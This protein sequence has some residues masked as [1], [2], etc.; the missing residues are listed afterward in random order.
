MNK[1]AKKKR[2][3]E[4]NAVQVEVLVF[5]R[6]S[7]DLHRKRFHQNVQPLEQNDPEKNKTPRVFDGMFHGFHV[8]NHRNST[9]KHVYFMFG[10]NKAWI[11]MLQMVGWREIKWPFSLYK[12]NQYIRRSQVR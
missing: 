2:L 5:S 11:W 1:H 6:E 7:G 10:S 9:L 3:E 12:A 8:L 4:E